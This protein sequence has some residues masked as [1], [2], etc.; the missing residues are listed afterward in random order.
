M[1][2]LKGPTKILLWAIAFTAACVLIW[3]LVPVKEGLMLLLQAGVAL[4]YWAPVLYGAIYAVGSLMGMPRTPLNVGAG[5][6]FP[7]EIALAL[8]MLS[9]A[10]V[11]FA[12]FQIARRLGADWVERKLSRVKSA[13]NILS[14]IEKEGFKFVLL[15]RLNPFIPAVLKDYG[16]GATAIPFKT[17][18]VASIL[19]ALPVAL[20]HIYLGLMGGIMVLD[21]GANAD[22]MHTGTLLIGGAVSL[23][24]LGFIIWLSDRT[25]KSRTRDSAAD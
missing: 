7:F 13:R 14:A 8:V 6:A 22:R 11:F 18:M 19:G 16:L 15:L 12:T 21:G 5:I 24:F 4:G 20:A 17:Y 1:P 10:V 23:V 3:K 9:S 2:A 25:L